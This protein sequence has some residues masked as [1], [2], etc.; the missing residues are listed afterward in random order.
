MSFLSIHEPEKLKEQAI[1][2]QHL[3]HMMVRIIG[4]G[5]SNTNR[6]KLKALTIWE[7]LKFSL[8]KSESLIKFQ[9]GLILHGPHLHP[10]CSFLVLSSELSLFLWMVTNYLLLSGFTRLPPTTVISSLAS[11][12]SRRLTR[13]QKEHG[14]ETGVEIVL[15][16]KSSRPISY[17]RC[18]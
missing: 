17:S 5:F 3:S 1:F 18:G 4:N 6:G 11:F 7:V 8:A 12:N 2:S 10:T 16:L 9:P 14:S 15:S 13:R